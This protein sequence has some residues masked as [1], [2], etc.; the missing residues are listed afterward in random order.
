[1]FAPNLIADQSFVLSG[2]TL[3]ELSRAEVELARLEAQLESERSKTALSKNL[4][5]LEAIATLRIDGE[6][7]LFVDLLRISNRYEIL[8]LESVSNVGGPL[9][10]DAFLQTLRDR[11]SVV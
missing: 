2:R 9:E 6:A 8:R 3:A 10:V 7:P 11:K 5:C 1:M 4:A